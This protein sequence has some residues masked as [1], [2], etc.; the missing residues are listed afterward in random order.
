MRAPF[1]AMEPLTLGV[2]MAMRG[3][4]T[5]ASARE[6]PTAAPAGCGTLLTPGCGAPSA[7]GA[8]QP[9]VSNVP[10]PA[11]AAVGLSRAE[12]L[13]AS[14]RIAIDTPSVKGSIALKGARIDDLILKDY[15]VTV[16]PD[17]PQVTLLSPAGDP[18]AYYA[19]RGF[20]GGGSRDLALPGGDTLWTAKG[21]GPLTP[22]SPITVSYTHLTL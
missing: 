11:G 17:S 13:V 15:R 6:S 7:G 22:S 8:P 10:Q 14:P 21:Q 5:K 19:E 2:S 3:E 12:A 18:H 20:V 4:A 9:G 16:E 1:S